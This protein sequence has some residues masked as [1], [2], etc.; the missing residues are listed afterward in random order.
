MEI[1]RTQIART[2]IVRIAIVHTEPR[3]LWTKAIVKKRRR[4]FR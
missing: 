4:A 1:A 3:P 2:E